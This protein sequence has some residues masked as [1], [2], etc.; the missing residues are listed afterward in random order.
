[1]HWLDGRHTVFGEIL[2]GT[3]V[4]KRMERISNGEGTT[5]DRISIKKCG[6]LSGSEPYDM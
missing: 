5:A 6:K 2:H 3:K 1:M 4:M